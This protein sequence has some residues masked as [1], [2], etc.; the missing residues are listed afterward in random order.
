MNI[1]YAA[2]TSVALAAGFLTLSPF[3][4]PIA[5]ASSLPGS[6][7]KLSNQ[8]TVYLQH[9]G[10]MHAIS[11]ES[12]FYALGYQFNELHTV[13][14]LPDS[15]GSPINLFRL[16]NQT[17]VYLYSQGQLHWIPSAS[18]FNEK[19]LKWSNIFTV[20]KLPALTGSPVSR[21]M[22]ALALS[23]FPDVIVG[24]S[25][26]IT[27]YA[28]N[29]NSQSWDHTFSGTVTATVKNGFALTTRT[30]TTPTT[31]V[32]V[33]MHNGRG[34][35]TLHAPSTVKASTTLTAGTGS[36]TQSQT[37]TSVPN[38]SSQIGWRVFNAKKQPVSGSTPATGNSTQKFYLE[39]V[40]AQGNIV[41]G[42]IARKVSAVPNPALDTMCPAGNPLQC[43][44]ATSHYIS[45]SGV[46]F[47]FSPF[48]FNFNSTTPTPVVF[49][50]A[51]S[52]ARSAQVADVVTSSGTHLAMSA[53]VN[54]LQ[55]VSGIKPNQHYTV[56]VQLEDSTGQ[57]LIGSLSP[58]S[59]A[60]ISI[61]SHGRSTP[62]SFKYSHAGTRYLY[63]TY[64][65]GSQTGSNSSFP[66]PDV[67]KIPGG[68]SN[69][70]GPSQFVYLKLLTNPF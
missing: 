50:M 22:A 37:F 44:V 3:A 30:T 59:N 63:Y 28:I 18:V 6:I 4:L 32:T 13:T 46:G 45:T 70:S 14:Q 43:N 60:S 52:R 21:S 33:P 42:T 20:S 16:P 25:K 66:S 53:V 31:T 8:N 29:P 48:S 23:G 57:P 38:T 15:I 47:S 17:K 54:G 24:H 5:N 41:T 40:D 34:T 10:K 69:A 68:I 39:P 2:V 1:R 27:L 56:K 58:M 35:V 55:E 12:M 36:S 7:Y 62:S 67:I 65:S 61:S 26:T 49:A 11:S 64:T 51:P 9:N 19:N